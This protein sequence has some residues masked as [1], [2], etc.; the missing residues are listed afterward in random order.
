MRHPPSDLDW[1][2]TPQAPGPAPRS[3]SVRASG[4]THGGPQRCPGAEDQPPEASEAP[5][6][7]AGKL[8]A[9]V[10]LAVA[11]GSRDPAAQRCVHALADQVRRA[12]PDVAVRTAFLE[13]ARPRLPDA[14]RQAVAE[15][16]PDRVA[17]VPLLL[18]TGYHATTDIGRAAALAGVPASDPLGPDP[19]LVPVLAE[20]LAAAGT[21]A[22]TP[23]VLAA[24]GSSDPR[25]AA[26]T[27]RQAAMLA[28]HLDVPV[29]AAYLSAARPTVAEALASL[30]AAAGRPAA[31]A[32]FL[33]APGLFHDELRRL[34][35]AW[36]SGP[37]GDHPAVAQL[38]VD[39]FQAARAAA[40]A[41]A[42]RPALGVSCRSWP[43]RAAARAGGWGGG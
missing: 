18:A 42:R 38:A 41:P 21:P 36:I 28:A 39:R 37:L 2:V 29:R 15:A 1:P 35:A 33:L 9:P 22:G 17:V 4:T 40:A 12:A 7:E 3:T 8:T 20:R 24:A 19:A 11:H 10:L 32:T 26:A 16:G 14:L 31:I 13:N 27:E 6:R 43:S 34:P 30:G 25:S 5:A 23:V